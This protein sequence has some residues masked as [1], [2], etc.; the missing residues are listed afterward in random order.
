MGPVE[1]LHNP[2]ELD[3]IKSPRPADETQPSTTIAPDN[4][5]I[6]KRKAPAIFVAAL[7]RLIAAI[8]KRAA[9]KGMPFDVTAMPGTKA[10]LRELAIRFDGKLT[11]APSTFDDYLF[12]LIRFKEGAQETNFY[13]DLFP[14]L[15]T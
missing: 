1:G 11:K 4:E 15:F 8:S 9:E 10:D 12:G 2:P 7:F 3:G 6:A 13:R 5:L 14:E